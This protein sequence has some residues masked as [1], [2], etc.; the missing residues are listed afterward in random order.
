M[1][2]AAVGVPLALLAVVAS[3]VPR[4][5]D[6]ISS[7]Y[8]TATALGVVGTVLLGARG[9]SF[10]RLLVFNAGQALLLSGLVTLAGV[11][12]G[13][14]DPAPHAKAVGLFFELAVVG[15][16]ARALAARPRL[17][18]GVAI[19]V[20]VLGQYVYPLNRAADHLPAA[21]ARIAKAVVAPIPDMRLFDTE[22]VVRAGEPHGRHLLGAVAY[23][24]A[25][26]V[27]LAVATVLARPG[28]DPLAAEEET[29][30]P[31][32]AT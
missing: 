31:P 23:G 28:T 14:I 18:V 9:L 24:S 26:L 20:A 1:V 17:A 22:T 11:T 21:P 25:W 12:W 8:H 13:H 30:C 2:L 27:A 7:L 32:N 16:V 6:G 4:D 19:G 5:A 3:L 15:G 10:P 29:P